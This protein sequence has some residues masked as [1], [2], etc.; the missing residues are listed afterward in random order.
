MCGSRGEW[1]F[2]GSMT[3]NKVFPVGEIVLGKRIPDALAPKDYIEFARN[4]FQTRALLFH[5]LFIST[6]NCLKTA[7]EIISG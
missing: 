4:L 1:E 2:S 3:A 6:M 5:I 7:N